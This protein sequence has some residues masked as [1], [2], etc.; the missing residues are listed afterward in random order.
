[1]IKR[2]LVTGAAGFIGSHLIRALVQKGYAVTGLD[3]QKGALEKYGE[4]V[5]EI[6]VDI[7]DNADMDS[8]GK[9]LELD[10]VI[11]LAAL[12]TPRIAERMPETT[13]KMNVYGTY[14]VLKLAKQAGAKKV[15]FAS[16]AHV[17]GISPKYMPTDEKHPLA[18]GNTYTSSKIL[19][20]QICNLFY[21]NHNI[22]YVALRMFNGY[23]PKQ[24]LDYFIPAMIKQAMEG[25]ITLR[26]R[27]ITKDFIYV[28]DMVNA[29]LTAV[30]SDYVGPLNV[31]TGIETTL[32][33]VASFIAKNL[34]AELGFAETEDR[35]PTHMRCDPTRIK[36]LGWLPETML[37]DGLSKTIEHFK[38]L[39][40]SSLL[41]SH[42]EQK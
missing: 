35:G 21:E 2:V 24:S 26:G 30:E 3:V 29:M 32:E 14:N 15:V 4:E 27:H 25:K 37:E 11:H 5:T 36:N 33:T 41:S 20:E 7:S 31:G 28:G 34:G 18:L 22:S 42:D 9:N 6:N 39:F 16:T 19:G 1:M 10:A 40:F 23:G 17:Y 8:L 38:P 12:A 13:F